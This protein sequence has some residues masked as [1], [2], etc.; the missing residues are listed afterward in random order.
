M[1]YPLTVN[2]TSSNPVARLRRVGDRVDRMQDRRALPAPDREAA[3][4]QGVE[5]RAAGDER[6]GVAALGER[7]A[8]EA[9]HG[10]G[11]HHQHPH[12]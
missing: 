12:G 8:V 4:P 6:D 10:A 1:S 5:V 11:A 9:A 2:S 7:R 3:L